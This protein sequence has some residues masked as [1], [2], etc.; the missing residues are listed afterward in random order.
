MKFIVFRCS[1]SPDY[2]VV[3]DDAHLK[4]VSAAVRPGDGELER[5]GEFPEMGEERVA[6]NEALAKDAIKRQGW[7][8]FESKTYDPVATSPGTMPG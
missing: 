3:T 2:F 6:F 4:G 5:V 8:R 1:R 7:Y